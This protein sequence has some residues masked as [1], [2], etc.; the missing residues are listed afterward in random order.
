MNHFQCFKQSSKKNLPHHYNLALLYQAYKEKYPTNPINRRAY[1]EIFQCYNI[2]IKQPKKDICCTCD[3][4]QMQLKMARSEDEKAKL[5]Q[6]L[7]KHHQRADKGY[8]AKHEDKN[9]SKSD[10]KMKTVCFDLQQCL[11]TPD[12]QSG[13]A[14]YKRWTFNLTVHDCDDA[15]A[16]CYLWFESLAKRGGNVIGSCIIHYLTKNL[17]S[18]VS[19]IIMYSDSC[20]GQNKNSYVS[21]ALLTALEKCE[22]LAIIDHK[23]LLPGHTRMEADTDHSLIERKKKKCNLKLEHPHD[24][25]Q[26]IRLV[27]KKKPFVVHEMEHP[28]F[29]NFAGFY[30]KSLVNRKQNTIGGKLNWREV[31]WLRYIKGNRSLV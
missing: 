6:D 3:K 21:A 23:F 30:S 17:D 12:L 24:W 1:A 19:H 10:L 4:L 8:R 7:A 26:L 20:G 22:N 13:E 27:G 5:K 18:S 28:E 31:R 16:F 15:Q 11:P 29:F 14:F 2:K 25:A 9:S